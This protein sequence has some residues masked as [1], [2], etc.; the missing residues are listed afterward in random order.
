MLNLVQFFDDVENERRYISGITQI[1]ENEIYDTNLWIVVSD[2]VYVFLKDLI[3]TPNGNKTQ[4]YVSIA[5]NAIE[6]VD[7]INVESDSNVASDSLSVWI[8]H[9][10]KM[11]QTVLT[12]RSNMYPYKLYQYFSYYNIL[13]SKGI[14]ITDENQEEK[15]IEVINTEDDALIEVLAEFLDMK[16]N[17]N[18]EL[19]VYKDYNTYHSRLMLASNK[20]EAKQIYEEFMVNYY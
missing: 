1:K 11:M 2:D 15:Y 5:V 3:V 6:S 17:M 18:E 14:F 13:M 19:A 4:Y 8:N 9:Y 12:S 16:D 7:T 10:D 20:E